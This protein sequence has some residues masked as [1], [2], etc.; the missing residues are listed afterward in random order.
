MKGFNFFKYGKKSP[1]DSI[2]A[3]YEIYFP[4]NYGRF[5]YQISVVSIKE[6]NLIL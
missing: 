6:R 2:L 3:M 1:G 5:H 4:F